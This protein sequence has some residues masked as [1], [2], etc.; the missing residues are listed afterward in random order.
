MTRMM[1]PSLLLAIGLLGSQVAAA[2]SPLKAVPQ[3]DLERYSGTWHEIARLPVYFERKCVRDITATYTPREDG[4]IGVTNACVRED[5]ERMVTEGVARMSGSNPA[6]LE[7]RFAPGWVSFVPFVW[8]DYW[9]IA[10]DSDYQWAIVGEPGREYLWFLSRTPS[11]SADAL[12][13]LKARARTLGYEL[14]ELIVVVP[15]TDGD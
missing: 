14:D 15:P 9:V 4:R 5:G 12:E 1:M 3:L 2:Q 13:G 10:I 7:V 11:I 6:K 8:A